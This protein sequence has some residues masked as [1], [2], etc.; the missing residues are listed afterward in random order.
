MPPGNIHAAS[1]RLVS[2]VAEAAGGLF[3]PLTVIEYLVPRSKQQV[4]RMSIF[5]MPDGLDAAFKRSPTSGVVDHLVQLITAGGRQAT[6]PP[7]R[8]TLHP[9]DPLLP[10]EISRASSTC[11]QYAE[12]HQ[13]PALRFNAITLRASTVFLKSGYRL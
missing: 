10:D 6:A 4:D 8:P 2:F 12:Q 3:K 11:K 5:A 7:A 9:L 13:L 1:H